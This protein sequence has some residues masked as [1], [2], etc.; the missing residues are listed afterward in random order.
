MIRGKNVEKKTRPEFFTLSPIYRPTDKRLNWLSEWF[1]A[2]GFEEKK[3][4]R[5]GKERPRTFW[6]VMRSLA[7]AFLVEVEWFIHR[8]SRNV[9]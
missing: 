1:F 2:I 8:L 7:W 4:R 6:T 9:Q 5:K 3:G